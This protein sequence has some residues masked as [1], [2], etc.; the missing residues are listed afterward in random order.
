MKK[1][2]GLGIIL[3]LSG[4]AS[5]DETDV[6]LP[7]AQKFQ[8]PPQEQQWQVEQERIG[9]II[10]NTDWNAM[11]CVRCQLSDQ[12]REINELIG[13]EM[14]AQRAAYEKLLK[15]EMSEE[16]AIQK[17]YVQKEYK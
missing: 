17:V 2:I 15:E 5:T 7:S 8:V 14:E 10:K 9:Q 6:L 4:C 3:F 11:P 13:K 16:E 12:E 1:L